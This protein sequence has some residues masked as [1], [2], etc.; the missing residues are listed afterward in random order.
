MT[1][2][3]RRSAFTLGLFAFA[4]LIGYTALQLAA[5]HAADEPSP[6]R[7]TTDWRQNRIWYDGNAETCVYEA[8]RTIYGKSRSF[9]AV[10]HTNKER[11]DATTKTK[12]DSDGREVF[13]HHMIER[14][15]TEN[16]D[17]KF[18]T[19]V[20]VGT[21][22]LDM[23]KMDMGSQEDCGASFKQF[24][25]EGTTAAW[26]QFSYFPDEGHRQGEAAAPGNYVYQDALSLVLRGYPF[27]APRELT[28]NVLP[29]QTTTKWSATQAQPH[30]V[31]HEGIE[32]LDLPVGKV[33]AHRLAVSPVEGANA[34]NTHHYWFAAE[35]GHSGKT[36]GLHVMVRYQGPMG[37]TYALKSQTRAAYWKR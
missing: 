19:M 22:K 29:D 20:Y 21:D 4:M 1:C 17:Y 6:V 35:G 26:H 34:D 23:V 10:L 18:S 11:F 27:D 9:E 15:P 8:T 36:P 16:Y 5:T 14:I 24:L 3:S 30:L 12:S 7:Y 25:H 13:K 33:R 32:E 31:R 2:P 28:L 37:I